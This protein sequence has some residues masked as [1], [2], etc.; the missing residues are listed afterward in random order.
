[1]KRV[2]SFMDSGTASSVR[3]HATSRLASTSSGVMPSRPGVYQ[4][5]LVATTTRATCPQPTEKIRRLTVQRR[6]ARYVTSGATLS[7]ERSSK[8]ALRNCPAL[9]TRMSTEPNASTAR[10]TIAAPPA[11]VATDLVSATAV[12]FRST[13]S[14]AVRSAASTAT[15]LHTTAAPRD[16]RCSA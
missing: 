15:S 4:P 10:A 2:S 3:S 16:A 7:T 9:F 11:G 8:A 6:L 13:I 14:R 5:R 1:M 12:P